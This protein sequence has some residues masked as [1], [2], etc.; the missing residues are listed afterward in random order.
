MSLITRKTLASCLRL[1]FMI[2]FVSLTISVLKKSQDEAAI[3]REQTLQIDVAF[4]VHGS[5]NI[6]SPPRK[7]TFKDAL[8]W[9][10]KITKAFGEIGD[11]KTLAGLILYAEEAKLML[12]FTANQTKSDVM[13]AI[14]KASSP[15]PLGNKTN[16]GKALKLCL[17]T[18]VKDTRKDAVKKFFVF[19]DRPPD[20][21]PMSPADAIKDKNIEVYGLGGNTPPSSWYI[22]DFSL[23]SMYSMLKEGPFKG[24]IQNS[25]ENE[26]LHHSATSQ[27]NLIT[28]QTLATIKNGLSNDENKL[29]SLGGSAMTPGESQEMNTE[30]AAQNTE[31][32]ATNSPT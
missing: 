10:K 22:H 6:T 4:I 20:D 3:K 9:V 11:N 8:D 21:D 28:P 29:S 5:K 24:G 1:T 26:M 31:N 25:S 18:L 13:E 7:K 14:E 23:D 30:N 2:L 16:T 19:T 32:I 12:N 17:E 27:S 15:P